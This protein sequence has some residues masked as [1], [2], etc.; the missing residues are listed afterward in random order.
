MPLFFLFSPPSNWEQGKCVSGLVTGLS[1]HQKVLEKNGALGQIT[2]AQKVLGMITV[3]T[4]SK[5]YNKVI[6]CP[7]KNG[8]HLPKLTSCANWVILTCLI[9]IFELKKSQTA[10]YFSKFWKYV[11]KCVFSFTV[12]QFQTSPLGSSV[13]YSL[14]VPIHKCP[15]GLLSNFTFLIIFGFFFVCLRLNLFYSNYSSS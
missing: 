1:A 10:V 4:C 9:K 6:W 2:K 7:Q 5:A 11:L 3:G 15:L 8:L 12:S 14:S 13:S